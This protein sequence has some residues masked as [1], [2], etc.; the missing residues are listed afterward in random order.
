[1]N[2][3]RFVG[4][5]RARREKPDTETAGVAAVTDT[6]GY[7]GASPVGGGF[8]PNSWLWWAYF[9]LNLANEAVYQA[10]KLVPRRTSGLWGYPNQVPTGSQL[11]A[12]GVKKHS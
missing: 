12:A 3:D 1:M 5:F 10:P 11:A 4:I 2:F 7:C 6:S 9:G 8:R